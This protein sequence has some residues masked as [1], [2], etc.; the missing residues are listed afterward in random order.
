MTTP[1]FE[2]ALWYSVVA[3]DD[4]EA[5]TNSGTEFEV[6]PCYSNAGT[7]VVECGRC[8]QPMTIV[9]AVLLDPQPEVS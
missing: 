3:R 9:S 8:R 7:V 1:V 5:C 4:N 2:P 6:N